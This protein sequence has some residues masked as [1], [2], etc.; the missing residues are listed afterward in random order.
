MF[1]YYLKTFQ[2]FNADILYIM[3]SDLFFKFGT[4]TYMAIFDCEWHILIENISLSSFR[5]DLAPTQ[6]SKP[7]VSD[8]C[9]IYRV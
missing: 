6:V 1:R 2:R 4:V 5:D 7:L 3:T 8:S 9:N